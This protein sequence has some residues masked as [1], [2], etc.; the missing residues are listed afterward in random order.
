MSRLL[1]ITDIEST[2]WKDD[3]RQRE[4]SEVIEWGSVL[5]DPDTRCSIGE[6]QSFI[7]PVRHSQLSEFCTRL[8]TIRQSQVDE[9]PVFSE[10]LE[11]LETQFLGDRPVTFASWGKYDREQ[12]QL[13]CKRNGVRWPFGTK[14]LNIKQEFAAWKRCRP[15]GI[16]Q[17]IASLG[18]VFQGTPHRGID[19][20]RQVARVYSLLLSRS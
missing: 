3:P 4:E 13:D 15:C 9:A 19:D 11:R 16:G 10:V 12:L 6:F 20:A 7:R 2:C 17:A 5:Y 18:M 1:L 8:T 14:H